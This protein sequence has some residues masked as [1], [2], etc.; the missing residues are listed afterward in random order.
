MK[1]K[2]ESK[3]GTVNHE[4]DVYTQNYNWLA[5]DNDGCVAIHEKEPIIHEYSKTWDITDIDFECDEIHELQL[6]IK[7]WE[8]L[9]YEIAGLDELTI[10]L[11]I[12]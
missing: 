9:K 10:V 2:F 7:N 1:I 5:I 8:S 3:C 12:N 6:N 11:E 4:I